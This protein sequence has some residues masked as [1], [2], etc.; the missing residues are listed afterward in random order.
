MEPIEKTELKK[1]CL[2]GNA[3]HVELIRFYLPTLPTGPHRPVK[4]LLMSNESSQTNGPINLI[5]LHV[6]PKKNLKDLA[7]QDYNKEIDI[8]NKDTTI[9]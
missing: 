9:H 1:K 3:H 4:S 2:K 8:Y 6:G 5:S 7:E